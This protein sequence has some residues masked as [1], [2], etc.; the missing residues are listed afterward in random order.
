MKFSTKLIHGNY[1][2]E[3]TGATNVP[4]YMSNAYAHSS[5][6]ELEN[7][8]KGKFPGYVYSRFSNPTVLEFE[9]RM[10]S[11]EGGLTATSAASGMSAIYMAITNIVHPGDEIIASTGLYGGTYTLISNLQNI[12]VKVIFLE[13]ISKKT[14]LNNI[15]ENTKLVY[16]ETIGNPKLDILDIES[17]GRV[18]KEKGIIFMVDSTISTPYLINPSKYGA[19]VIIHS[20]SKYINGTSNAIGGMI[21]DC[22]SEKYKNH[23]YENF[24]KY[25]EKYD[26]LAFT[27]KLKSTSGL[28]IGASMSPFNAFLSL[29]GIETLSLRMKK[30]CENAMKIAS[31]LEKSDKVTNVNYPN[32]KSSKYYD[33]ATKYY[34]DGASGILTFRLGTK[35][36]AYKFL[37]KLKLILDTTNIGD[38]KTIII[39]PASTICINNTEEEREKMAVYDDLLR[40]SVGIEDIED[41]LEDIDRALE[42]I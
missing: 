39:H 20:T 31:Y 5:P 1:N 2:L 9:R 30:H 38:C 18:C 35:E 8:F 17:V 34:A 26:K 40:L 29:T 36:N 28:D 15:N 19:D 6:Q 23:R 14:L 21:V 12:G 7:V 11:I 33:L 16:T 27:A 24:Q 37:A 22:G 25:A 3:N 32:L 13:D 42:A 41:I 4:I 10:A